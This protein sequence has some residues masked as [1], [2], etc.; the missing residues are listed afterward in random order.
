VDNKWHY[1]LST[2]SEDAST[3]NNARNVANPAVPPFS[4]QTFL[5]YLVRFI[6]ADDQVRLNDFMS[7]YTL[8]FL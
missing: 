4:A 5:E 1:K 7:F 3:H 6:V 2:H 8:T